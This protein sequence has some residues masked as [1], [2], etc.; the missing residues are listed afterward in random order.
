[1][2][3]RLAARAMI[4]VGAALAVL[5]VMVALLFARFSQQ[6]EEARVLVR[7]TSGVIATTNSLFEA[8]LQSESSERGYLITGSP[9]YLQRYMQA[10]DRIPGVQ[11]ELRKLTSDDPLQQTR[12]DRLAQVIQQKVDEMAY[13]IR[14]HDEA[15]FVEAQR[16]VQT[17]LGRNLM[18]T[19]RAGIGEMI[20]DQERLLRTR[21]VEAQE[22]QKRTLAAAAAGGVLVF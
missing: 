22:A 21:Q 19:I 17:H 12:L 14:L 16:E 15:G 6:F 8:V 7:R 18:L 10:R 3:Q 4:A 20:A 13:T 9:D 5:F 1:M 11:S 2:T